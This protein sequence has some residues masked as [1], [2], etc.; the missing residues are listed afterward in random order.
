MM[1][2]VF[3]IASTPSVAEQIGKVLSL[4]EDIAVA[5]IA[6]YGEDVLPQLH[7][8]ACDIVAIDGSIEDAALAELTGRIMNTRPLPMVIFG[9]EAD[10]E[11]I[12]DSVERLNIGALSVVA[13]PEAKDAATRVA[14]GEGLARNLR[15]MS[16]IKVERRWDS[17][18]FESLQKIFHPEA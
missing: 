1:T 6:L 18:R 2:R 7:A 9:A 10:I 11:R 16:E 17:R 3:V 12:R 4:G 5:R 8:V 13:L 15:L 14:R